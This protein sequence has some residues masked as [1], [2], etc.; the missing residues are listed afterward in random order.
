VLGSKGSI[1]PSTFGLRPTVPALTL[2]GRLTR[3]R[4]AGS[5]LVYTLTYKNTG[6]LAR[7]T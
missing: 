5:T 6:A 1:S 3:P 2:T 7:P 4:R